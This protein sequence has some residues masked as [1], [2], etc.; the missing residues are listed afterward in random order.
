VDTSEKKLLRW[1]AR[2]DTRIPDEGGK[3]KGDSFIHRSSGITF[4]SPTLPRTKRLTLFD[5]APKIRKSRIRM[6]IVE[7]R[8]DIQVDDPIV[9][10]PVSLL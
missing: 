3:A 1:P 2:S 5:A 4:F 6:E 9:V 10:F 8:I 7:P